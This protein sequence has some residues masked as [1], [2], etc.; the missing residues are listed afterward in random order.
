MPVDFTLPEDGFQPVDYGL[1]QLWSVIEELLPLGLRGMLGQ[2][3]EARQAI[4]D[5][6]FRKAQ[7]HIVAYA[8]AAGGAGA[9]PLPVVNVPLVL[10]AQAKMLHTIAEIY[11]QPMD[12]Q[13][14][15]EIAGALGFGFLTRLGVRELVKLVPV[16]GLGEGVSALYAA[17][18]T[19]ALAP[20]CANTSAASAEA[21]VGRR[22]HSPALRRG[23]KAEQTLD[24]RA[25]AA[26]DVVGPSCQSL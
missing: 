24:R 6:L 18:S 25:D 4:R 22:S 2:T 19:Y 16:P 10:A 5:D 14:M 23:I 20:P 17:A 13:R 1:E 8:M 26:A 3:P 11:R 21:K 15:A 9:V 12:L 7:P